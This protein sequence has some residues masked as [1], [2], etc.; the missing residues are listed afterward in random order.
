MMF[1]AAWVHG[2]QQTLSQNDQYD[3]RIENWFNI[4]DN[5]NIFKHIQ[6]IQT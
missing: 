6:Q 5:L 2:L 3:S 4:K 1:R